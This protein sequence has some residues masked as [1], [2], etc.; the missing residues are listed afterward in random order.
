M[1]SGTRAFARNVSTVFIN[2]ALSLARSFLLS[3]ALPKLLSIEGYADYRLF[4][5]YLSYIGLF[6]FGLVDGICLK[7]AG[8]TL[9]AIGET[10]IRMYTRLLIKMN[11]FNS[12][13]LLVGTLLFA[14]GELRYVG[15]FIAIDVNLHILLSYF[16]AIMQI[17]MQFKK[18]TFN[19]CV[20]NLLMIASLPIMM[21]LNRRGILSGNLY[22]S[23]YLL[24]E[25]ITLLIVIIRTPVL[26]FGT[27][28]KASDNKAEIIQLFKMGI[29]LL[30]AALV[31]TLVLNL[32]RQFVSILFSKRDYAIYSFA[33]SFM[34]LVLSLLV[35][36]SI[37][38]YP[39]LKQNGYDLMRQFYEKYIAGISLLVFG[40]LSFVPVLGIFIRWYLPGYTDSISIIELIFPALCTISLLQIVAVNYYK[41]IGKVKLY[42]WICLG[43]VLLSLA[44]NGVAY[45]II[46]TMDSI[47]IATVITCFVWF[48]ACD[49]VLRF[50][51]HIKGESIS[52]ILIMT[53]T[54]YAAN[55]GSVFHSR[56][57]SSLVYIGAFALAS[58]YYI[59][60]KNRFLNGE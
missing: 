43:A 18:Y 37:V 25:G 57:I 3:L 4:T 48:V 45:I 51:M 17:T 58:A 29:L 39:T 47:A 9:D 7:F 46:G 52:Y 36:M 54:Y 44:L 11:A 38:L 22:I 55:S 53:L 16:N 60:R 26:I 28:Q 13:L 24:I 20:L 12:A 49:A 31:A 41:A 5:L 8:K 23:M 19:G 15:V 59:F 27:A 1:N 34:N 33:Y 40:G 30:I 10:R 21:L 6:H 32:D 35:A 42:L 56:V 14:R 50:Q 2:N